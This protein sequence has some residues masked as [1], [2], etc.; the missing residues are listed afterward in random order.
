[1]ILPPD[2]VVI[3]VAEEKTEELKVKKIFTI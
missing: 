2:E 1:M 3:L